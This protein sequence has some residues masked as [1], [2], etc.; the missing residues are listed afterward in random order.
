M[1]AR[2]NMLLD[3]GL[4]LELLEV[5]FRIASSKEPWERQ[6][7]LLTVALRDHVSPQEAEG[8]TKKCLTRIWLNPPPEAAPMIAWGTEHAHLA[9]DRRILHL[10]AVL[11]TFPFAG[12][13]ATVIGR[14][15][16]LEGEVQ[17]RDVRR[18]VREVWGDKASVDVAARKVYTTFKSL[19]V[20]VGSGREPMGAAPRLPVPAP[21]AV[22]V[23]HSL[24]LTRQTHAVADSD[25]DGAPELFWAALGQRKTGYPLLSRH[26]EGRGRA[27]WSD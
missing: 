15:L 21:I 22:W 11:A 10:A 14:A 12:T 17:A 24:L 13:V 7:R 3:R 23:V 18:R 8:K 1:R 20:L 2:G 27:V 16:A 5:A 26:T 25:I 9:G 4:N 6:R 19:G